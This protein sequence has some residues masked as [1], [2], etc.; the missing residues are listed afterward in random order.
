E[1]IWTIKS[2]DDGD[3]TIDCAREACDGIVVGCSGSRN[4]VPLASVGRLTREFDPK[5]TEQAVIDGLAKEKA[6]RE[7]GKTPGPQD[8][9]PQVVTPYTL[10][11]NRA[12]HPFY[13]S[14]YRVSFDGPVIRF[15]SFST[16]ARSHSIA[17]VCHVPEDRLAAWRTRIDALIEGFQPAPDPIWLRLL[18]IIGL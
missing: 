17:I 7:K 1:T 8:I 14:D 11:Y 9:P 12:G 6:E 5:S 2:G 15:L 18:A 16:G 10:N 3:F 13:D 4:W